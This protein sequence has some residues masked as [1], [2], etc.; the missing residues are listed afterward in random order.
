KRSVVLRPAWPAW[1]WWCRCA[2]DRWR[3]RRRPLR[4]EQCPGW[5]APGQG[6]RRSRPWWTRWCPE[7]IR[8]CP[9]R[10]LSLGPSWSWWGVGWSLVL[11]RDGVQACLESVGAV[12]GAIEAFLDALETVFSSHSTLGFAVALGLEPVG[13]LGLGIPSVLGL[14]ELLFQ[15]G[16][17][18]ACPAGVGHGLLPRCLGVAGCLLGLCGVVA[19]GLFCCGGLAL[20]VAGRLALG[21]GLR[22]PFETAIAFMLG[23]GLGCAC[24]GGLLP[25]RGRPLVGLVGVGLG[26]FGP[27]GLGI[28]G[29]LGCL[30]VF[31]RLVGLRARLVGVV[32]G[33]GAGG[34]LGLGVLVGLVGGLF[35]C[36]ACRVG[37]LG[38]GHGGGRFGAG[39][40]GL[41][42]GAGDLALG[43]GTRGRDGGL[44]PGGGGQFGQFLADALADL[45]QALDNL[46]GARH[47][48]EQARGVAVAGAGGLGVV[49]AASGA[50]GRGAGACDA[51]SAVG[52]PVRPV[53]VVGLRLVFGGGGLGRGVGHGLVLSEVDVSPS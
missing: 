6:T 48:A 52:A 29:A 5:N 47:G 45:V 46:L 44:D 53:P 32:F 4:S 39:G 43:L 25:R 18:L 3:R 34:G 35:C 28:S 10:I 33:L 23:C 13:T 21:L 49:L 2:P 50:V 24:G 51:A 37:G 41:G 8:G 11:L 17:G 42:R 38:T 19:G 31:T 15:R 1:C 12:F 9:G 30:G 7:W 27:A 40:F 14:G 20:G 26:A 22:G 16:Q 36:G